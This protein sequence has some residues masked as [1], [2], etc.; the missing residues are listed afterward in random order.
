MAQ[1]YKVDYGKISL[2]E[3]WNLSPNWKGIIAW[4]MKTLGSP[5][6]DQHAHPHPS[7]LKQ[8]EMPEQHLPGEAASAMAPVRRAIEQMGFHSPK[9]VHVPALRSNVETTA[10]TFL[11]N[12]GGIIARV[13]YSQA[14][15]PQNTITKLVTFF[16]TVLRDGRQLVTTNMTPSF[17]SPPKIV[18]ERKIEAPAAVLYELHKQRIACFPDEEIRKFATVAERDAFIDESELEAYNFQLHRGLYVP[19]AEPEGAERPAGLERAA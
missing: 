13:M 8:Y 10:A 5:V 1:F 6:R 3:Y 12:S 18:M 14:T 16:I 7:L 9:W 19:L 15:T 4:L 11:H 2:R 17:Q